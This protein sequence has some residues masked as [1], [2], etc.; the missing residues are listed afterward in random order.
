MNWHNC[1]YPIM[2]LYMEWLWM[3]IYVQ[4]TLNGIFKKVEQDL[5]EGK[6]V[7]FSGTPCQ[8]AG[9]NS[10]LVHPYENLLTVDFICHGVPSPVFYTNMLKNIEQK[11]QC[12]LKDI[13]F[14]EKDRGWRQQT[15]KYYFSN[16][17]VVRKPS[18]RTFY[19]YSFLDN[20]SLR[21]SCFSCP[22][23]QCHV[24]DITMGDFWGANDVEDKGVSLL[25]LNTDK[26][27]VFYKEISNKFV[28]GNVQESS[29]KECFRP[30]GT[31]A[32]YDIDRRNIFFEDFFKIGYAATEKKYM[33]GVRLKQSKKTVLER[34]KKV[35]R[36]IL[37]HN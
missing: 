9:L 8:I 28:V 14:R 21:K 23:V 29:I 5:K 19:Y 15:T 30:R 24:S 25:I 12:K 7:L 31:N 20:L 18:L 34:M 6:E 2:V 10:F 11:Y 13:T 32:S 33:Q 3:I 1:F 27:K 22:F 37:R 35:F 36:L 4:S 16:M 26:G 17:R